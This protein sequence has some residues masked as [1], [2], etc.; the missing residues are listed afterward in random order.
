M[1]T[2]TPQISAPKLPHIEC[3]SCQQKLP[4]RLT[5][6]DEPAAV[7]QCAKCQVPFV[8]RCVESALAKNASLIRLGKR[9]FDVSGQSN[10]SLS[11]RQKA[12]QLSSRRVNAS[13]LEQRRSK[14]VDQSLVVPAVKLGPGFVPY[15][16]PFQIMVANLSREGVGLVHDGPLDC[17]HIAIEFSP[18]STSPIQVIVRL[19][20]QRELTA[21]YH[22]IGGVFFV[23]L[24][25]I[26]TH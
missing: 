18:T 13:Q 9:S 17:E 8:A 15:D 1:P 10:I 21:P 11:K 23:R 4:L 20:R 25:S 24:G 5:V 6:G 16:E 14:R 7:W 22:E 26:A 12:I 2:Q 19:V 3:G